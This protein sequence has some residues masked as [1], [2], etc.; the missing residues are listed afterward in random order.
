MIT[1][2]FCS[3]SLLILLYS[4]ISQFVGKPTDKIII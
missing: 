4:K 3:E 2:C 1:I